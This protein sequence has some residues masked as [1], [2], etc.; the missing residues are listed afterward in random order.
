MKWGRDDRRKASLMCYNTWR[1]LINAQMQIFMEN[2]RLQLPK[3]R[4]YYNKNKEYSFYITR[5]KKQSSQYS[6]RPL[7]RKT[8]RKDLKNNKL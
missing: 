2:N 4:Y 3:N 8:I 1:L 6:K 5:E 7:K